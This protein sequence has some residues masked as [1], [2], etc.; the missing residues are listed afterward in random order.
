MSILAITIDLSFLNLSGLTLLGAATIV[1]FYVGKVARFAKL[2]SLI[3]YMVVG[4]ILG[5]SIL[6]LFTED[7]MEQLSFITEIALGFVAFSIGSELNLSSLKRL[8]VGIIS[9]ILAESFGAF[10]VVAIAM[11]LLTRDLP[12]SLIF[13][14][15][16]PASAPAGTVAVIQE[17]KARGSLTKTLYAVVGFD[18]G[19][20]I[21]I[22]GFA[23][24]LAKN[25]LINEASGASEGIMPALLDPAKEIGLSFIVGGIAG[26]VFFQLVRKL[27]SARDIL[28]IVFGFILI[29]TGLSIRWHL[30]LILTNMVVGFV[31]A[32]S[33]HESLLNRVTSP[34]MEV[35]P[36]LFV[37]FFCLAGAHLEL[38]SLPALGTV[39]L[40]Y[41][42]G[43]SAG[44]IGG[45]RLGAMFGHVED[46][47]K[48][49]VGLGILSQAGV[50]I[51]LSLIVKH[52]LTQLNAEYNLRHALDIGSN[53]LATV[54]ATCIFFEIVGPI[55]T[56]IALKKA[57]EIPETELK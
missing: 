21:I 17:C 7:S 48:K 15:M 23:A 41:I 28:I 27:Q 40:V 53:V 26:L 4:V 42:L 38:S 22:F 16:A 14:S 24:A 43:R 34:L 2:P 31:L 20:A 49:Y 3:G 1:A 13:G 19:L 51:G 37:L 8:G 44:L 33:R 45:A 46:K 12:L 9:I 52:E 35:M 55:L 39:G 54:T 10:F 25:L 11:Y 29:C 6:H 47:V 5:P 50:A 36:L 30:S 57:G 18:D 32:N 56:K